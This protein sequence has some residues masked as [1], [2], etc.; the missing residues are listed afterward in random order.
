MPVASGSSVPACPVF[1]PV[2]RRINA[3][4]RAE[5]MPSGLSMTSQPCSPLPDPPPFAGEGRV[6][7]SPGS[8]GLVIILGLVEIAL[9][10]RARQ[11]CRDPRGALEGIVE[12]KGDVRHVPQLDHAGET[13]LQK[14][15]AA[16]QPRYD[17][18]GIGAAERHH[19]SGRVAQIGAEAY[20]GDGDVG[21]AQCRVAQFARTQQVGQQMAQ[22]L[23][24]PQLPLTGW[25]GTGGLIVFASPGH[26][27]VLGSSKDVIP[28][29]RAAA[30]RA[31]PGMTTFGGYWRSTSPAH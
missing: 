5:V 4:A 14:R 22:L 16:A 30:L 13:V 20:L 28:R 21:L 19:E 2:A 18:L 10:S 27:L 15:R 9:D 31:A 1:A 26:K 24:H 6:G 17:L 3:T 11:Q 29:R 12:G 23:A 7:A 25:P 8:G